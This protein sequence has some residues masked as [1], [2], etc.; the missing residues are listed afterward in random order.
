MNLVGALQSY[1]TDRDR[2][3]F[4]ISKYV[5]LAAIIQYWVTTHWY[6]VF[7]ADTFLEYS[8]CATFVL[9]ASLCLSYYCIMLWQ[10]TDALEFFIRLDA[11]VE[12][13]KCEII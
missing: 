2:I 7:E 1:S 5:A 3:L 12:E 10:R 8:L 9:T 13:S 11:L 4:K 6:V